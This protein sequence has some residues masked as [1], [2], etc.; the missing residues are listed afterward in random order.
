MTYNWEEY[1]R[2]YKAL[3]GVKPDIYGVSALGSYRGM[4]DNIKINYSNDVEQMAK[5]L[6]E[7]IMPYYEDIKAE[8]GK[9]LMPS[10]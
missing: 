7:L 4:M 8:P 6:N 1:T 5:K 9:A 3:F 10:K 2:I